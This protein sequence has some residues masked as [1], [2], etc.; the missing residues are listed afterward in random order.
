MRARSNVVVAATAATIVTA[1]ALAAVPAATAAP[2]APTTVPVSEAVASPFAGCTEDLVD[3][4]RALGAVDYPN[5]EVEPYVA[6]NPTNRENL[7][8]VWQQDRWDGAGSRGNLA[9]VSFDGGESWTVVDVTGSSACTGNLFWTRASDPWVTFGPDGAAYF[10][11]LGIYSTQVPLPETLNVDGIVVS[12]S[13]DGGLTWGDPATLVL[14]TSPTAFSDKGSITADPN[15][16]DFVYAIWDVLSGPPSGNDNPD[17]GAHSH[18]FTVATVFTRSTDGG[19]TWEPARTIV[20]PGTKHETVANQVVVRPA[21]VGGQ[22]VDVVNLVVHEQKNSGTPHGRHLAV[23]I[24][25]DHGS[26]WSDP[27]VA[28]R[29]LPAATVDP[30][31]GSRVRTGDD[32][33]DA[34][35]D[36]TSGDL[37]AVWPDA[38]FSGGAYNDV[39]L[40]V[41]AD[42]GLHWSGPVA[43]PRVLTGVSGLNRQAFTPQVHVSSDGRLAVAYYD[44]RRNNG[45]DGDTETDYFVSQCAA[46]DPAE[47]DLCAGDWV[48][49]RV[50]EDSF[51]LRRAPVAGGLFLGDYV[52]LSDVPGAFGT[53]FTVSSSADP[54]TIRYSTVPFTP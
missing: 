16:G 21:R 39:A 43:V 40:S 7:I 13:E 6:V 31:S 17:A 20:E 2:V 9:G 46:P 30:N 23:L 49:T 22:L 41:S 53:V 29:M 44:F 15:D 4:Q 51:D 10:I 32:V 34:A 1:F 47:P 5:S 11:H 52:G 33:P 28:A 8:A 50:T 24:S 38:R 12:R 48:E 3:L 45:A 19:E 27:I 42:G 14:D 37:Y 18:A 25:G 35:V 36:P 26:T 54:A